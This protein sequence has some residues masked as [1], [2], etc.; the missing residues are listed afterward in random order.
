[1]K[2]KK[3]FDKTGF[4]GSLSGLG[5]SG[6]PGG[7]PWGPKRSIEAKKAKKKFP[8]KPDFPDPEPDFRISTYAVEIGA[9][10]ATC[11]QNF[12]PLAAVVLKWTTSLT[13]IKY[14]IHFQADKYLSVSKRMELSRTLHLT[15]VQI[16]TWF[17]NRRTK[18]KKQA[19]WFKNSHCTF[20]FS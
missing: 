15:E 1:M 7:W 16:K 17:Q 13:I 10:R 6:T 19:W 14:R 12:R 11:S 20:F 9:K 2:K 4:P 3:I 5:D 8:E 18:W